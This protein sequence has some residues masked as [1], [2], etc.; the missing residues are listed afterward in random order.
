MCKLNVQTA[1]LIK[2]GTWRAILLNFHPSSEPSALPKGR[3]KILNAQYY[4]G[5]QGF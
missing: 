2:L 1:G 5:S 3:G 4:Q